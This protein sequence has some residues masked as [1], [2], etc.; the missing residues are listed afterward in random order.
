M[1]KR[2]DVKY[3]TWVKVSLTVNLCYSA[4]TD[5]QASEPSS[6]PDLYLAGYF[7]LVYQ[8][9]SNFEWKLILAQNFHLP[10]FEVALSLSNMLNRD[11][12]CSIIIHT[13]C[14]WVL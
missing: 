8:K 1:P 13:F 14:V 7:I 12:D 6:S 9:V 4:H 5:N 10:L 11:L 2:S 3:S